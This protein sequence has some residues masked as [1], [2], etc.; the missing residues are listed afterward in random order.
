VSQEAGCIVGRADG[1]VEVSWKGYRLRTAFQPIFTL[2]PS[3]LSVAA[4]ECLLRPHLEGRPVSPARFL[5]LLPAEQ[6]MEV[7]FLIRSIHLLNA[8]LCLGSDA[9]LFINMHPGEADTPHR[10]AATARTLRLAV[11]EAGLTARNITC[12]VTEEASAGVL[13]D[14]VAALRAE[15]YQIAVDDFGAAHSDAARLE[16]LRPDIVKFDGSWTGRLMATAAGFRLLA[17]MIGRCTV[18]GMPV[19]LE[20]IERPWQ[21]ELAERAGAAMLQG[22]GIGRPKLASLASEGAAGGTEERL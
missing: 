14:L 8:A 22:Y 2:G 19:V 20:G 5:D 18:Q 12:E 9:R 4:H 11:R 3:G 15:G 6:R 1:T 10:I 7:H 13:V 16:A 21:V 17:D